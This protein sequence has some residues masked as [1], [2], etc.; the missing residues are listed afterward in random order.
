[1]GSRLEDICR[2]IDRDLGDS[3]PSPDAMILFGTL[4]RRI[5]LSFDPERLNPM[6]ERITRDEMLIEMAVTASKRSTCLRRR[7]GAIVEY[8]G[9]VLS[10]G[11]AGS[12]PGEP[13]CIEVGCEPGT[14]GGCLRTVHAEANAILWA[15]KYGIRVNGATLYCTDAPCLACARLM[16]NAGIA[17]VKY[18]RPYRLTAGLELLTRAGVEHT[19]LEGF[20]L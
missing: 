12:L 7:V 9:R 4:S 19:H 2:R 3:S 10:I 20:D 6:S 11:Y 5:G 18:I 16:I 15:T 13:H 1:M 8:G 17:A 14:D